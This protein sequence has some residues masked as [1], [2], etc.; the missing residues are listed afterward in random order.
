MQA[1]Q[2]QAV[3]Y[4]ILK[5]DPLTPGIGAEIS[6][7]DLSRE[8][9]PAACEEIRH[10]LAEH[11]VIFFRDQ[12]LTLEQHKAFGRNFGELHI[13]P[14]YPGPEGHPEIFEIHADGNSTFVAGNHWHSDVSCEEEPPLGSIL[15][16][17]K[18]PPSGGDTL[19]ANMY[20][21]YEALSDGMQRYL[22]GLTALHAS[23][24][25]YRGRYADRGVDDTGKVYP[26]AEHPVVR[27][28][29]VSGRKGLFVNSVFTVRVLGMKKR[30]SD[31][32]LRFLCEHMN[33][34]EYQCRFRWRENSIAFWDNRCTQHHAMWDYFPHVRHG[35]RVTIQ[36]DRPG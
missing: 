23:E 9:S 20:Q 36:G 29:P 16:L 21:A 15:H 35:Y 33:A 8:L 25:V 3:G 17:H 4:S 11:L 31:Y 32:L 30:E 22:S 2:E 6:G 18:V 13:H 19:F 1:I 26:H 28:H 27:T 12:E 7:V 34:P 5:V 24:H 10:A 14:A